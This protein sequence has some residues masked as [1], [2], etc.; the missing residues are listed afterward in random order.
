[1]KGYLTFLPFALGLVLGDCVNAVVWIA[2]GY[3]TEVG[4]QI[5]PG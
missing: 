3:L 5:M 2:L 4:Y 1:M